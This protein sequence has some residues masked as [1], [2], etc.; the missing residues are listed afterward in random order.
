VRELSD[1]Q[2]ERT[3][4]PDIDGVRAI[5]ILSVV[6]YH[7]SEHLL[8]GGFTGVDI[9][10]VISGYLIG[11]HI[12]SEIR[13]GTFSFLSFYK[14]R[15][16]RILPAFY[17][18]LALVFIASVVL[19]SPSEIK[20][21]AMSAI[22]SL[23]SA[24]NIY[25]YRR[26][27]DYFVTTGSFNPLLMTWSLGV[28]EQFY[29]LAPLLMVLVARI[30]RGLLLPSIMVVTV[31]SFALAVHQLSRYPN[32]AFYLLPTRAWELGVGVTLALSELTRGYR[33][34]KT[35]TQ[36]VSIL[37]LAL[38]LIPMYA[39][40][41]STPFPGASALPSVIG[42]ALVIMTPGSWINA[43]ILA[44]SPFVFIGRISYSWYLMH[45]PILIYMGVLPG[46][47]MSSLITILAV[48]ISLVAAILS[49]Y[50]VEQPLRASARP[51][52]PL[53]FRYAGVTIAFLL[54]FAF[55]RESSWTPN[56]YPQISRYEEAQALSCNA[57]YGVDEPDL[58]RTCYNTADSRPAVVLWG[59]S[60]SSM[61]APVLRQIANSQGYNFVQMSKSSCLPIIGS[62]LSVTNYP[63][64]VRNC[65][66]FNDEVLR[67]ALFDKRVRIVLMTGVW[68][69]PFGRGA[70][71]FDCD[72]G[73]EGGSCVSGGVAYVFSDSL[74]N[75][76]RPL[77]NAG[78]KVMLIDD[79]PIFA[80]DPLLRYRT[81]IIPARHILASVLGEYSNDMGLSTPDRSLAAETA[82]ELMKNTGLQFPGLELIELKSTFC[83]EQNYC[84]Y[85][86]D[87]KLLYK[88]T[89]HLTNDGAKY[90]LREFKLPNL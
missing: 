67:L 32:Y 10:F 16:K 31:L 60:H 36:I 83:N 37:G 72:K 23:L 86:A 79:V 13:A 27:G 25:F 62:A 41:P 46:W 34:T 65:I 90:A 59:D 73:R 1:G 87:G 43:T 30:R 77:R 12:Y 64:E 45:Y 39:L 68:S 84:A 76:I 33:L 78:I 4:R 28:E 61:L 55:L 42:A 71:P 88:D 81:S 9:F 58:S 7:A 17:L 66:H 24:S 15:A 3:Y 49:Y 48:L 11:G 52:K 19:L 44:S 29:A 89:G 22:S 35:W 20:V 82:T 75:A 53:L 80:F 2:P 63:N 50:L 14:R 26:L 54:A 56:R 6:I 5:A 47:E 18:V 8:P 51:A 69:S 38:M 57:D 40:A 21:L 74:A 85:M 70:N